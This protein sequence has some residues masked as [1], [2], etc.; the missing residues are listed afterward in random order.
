MRIAVPDVAG[1]QQDAAVTIIETV[2]LTPVIE[3]DYSDDIREG[4]VI[5]SDPEPA[6]QMAK[7][8]EVTLTV[9]LGIKQVTVP[10]VVGLPRRRPRSS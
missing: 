4:Y 7:N 5:S 1:R 3:T 6:M 8:E 2:G 10:S 9:S